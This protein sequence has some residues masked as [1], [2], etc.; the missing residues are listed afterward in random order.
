MYRIEDPSD[1]FSVLKGEEP[2]KNALEKVTENETCTST[3]W[4]S[5]RVV[6]MLEV[7]KL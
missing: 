2:Q 5:Q 1:R 4:W 3:C 7:H 6:K